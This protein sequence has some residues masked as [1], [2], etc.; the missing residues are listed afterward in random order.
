MLSSMLFNEAVQFFLEHQNCSAMKILEWK[1]GPLFCSNFART[2]VEVVLGS[3]R[4]LGPR[5]NLRSVPLPTENFPD[6]VGSKPSVQ[7]RR[8]PHSTG[9]EAR[10][11]SEAFPSHNTQSVPGSSRL[12]PDHPSPFFILLTP[13]GEDHAIVFSAHGSY[14]QFVGAIWMRVL[15][16]NFISFLMRRSI[17]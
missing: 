2:K 9:T 1:H 13:L 15:G 17:T 6:F 5:A 8:Y 12:S 16:P 4:D 14:G 7:R 3:P 10:M 11:Y